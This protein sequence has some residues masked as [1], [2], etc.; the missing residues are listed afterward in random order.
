MDRLWTAEDRLRQAQAIQS[1]QPWTHSTGA[2]TEDGKETS[3]RNA[4]KHGLRSTAFK[5]LN[6]AMKEQ[7]EFLSGVEVPEHS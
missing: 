5:A 1:W 7:R 3:K 4:T 2:K 6:R